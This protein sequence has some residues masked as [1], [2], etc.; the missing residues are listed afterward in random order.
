MYSFVLLSNQSGQKSQ[1]A[2]NENAQYV[3]A[4]SGNCFTIWRFNI[5]L[6]ILFQFQEQ[7]GQGCSPENSDTFQTQGTS[8]MG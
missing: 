1:S 8:N 3:G 4:C 6:F 2:Q 7:L 5:Y